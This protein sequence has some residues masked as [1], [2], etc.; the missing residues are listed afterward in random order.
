[1]SEE[2]VSFLSIP[3][4]SYRRKKDKSRYLKTTTTAKKKHGTKYFTPFISLN[5]LYNKTQIRSDEKGCCELVILP[6]LVGSPVRTF[7]AF[8]CP[9]G[10]TSSSYFHSVNNVQLRDGCIMSA[11]DNYEIFLDFHFYFYFFRRN[12]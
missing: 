9:S 12:F 3:L 10:D 4:P 6:D 11:Y 7:L 1:M 2:N 5:T 8:I